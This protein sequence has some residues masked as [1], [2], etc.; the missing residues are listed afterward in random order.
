[1]KKIICAVICLMMLATF[2]TAA[3]ADQTQFNYTLQSRSVTLRAPARAGFKA[4]VAGS[5][6]VTFR[7]A[8]HL[9]NGGTYYTKSSTKASGYGAVGKASP[10]ITLSASANNAADDFISARV[11]GYFLY[12]R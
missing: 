3:C 2:V 5:L 1:M 6:S 8:D 7:R 4:R 10:A 9:S 11:S 12:V